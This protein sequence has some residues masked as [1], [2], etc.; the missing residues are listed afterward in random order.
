M[1]PM[2][3]ICIPDT[4]CRET[5]SLIDAGYG[6]RAMLPKQPISC[7]TLIRRESTLRGVR[8]S[9]WL[10]VMILTVVAVVSLQ[11][12]GQANARS[13]RFVKIPVASGVSSGVSAGCSDG[14]CS[15]CFA[16]TSL[17]ETPFGQKTMQDLRLGDHVRTMDKDG[18]IAFSPI[19]AFS[20]RRPHQPAKYIRISTVAGQSILVTTGHYMF[21]KGSDS[22]SSPNVHAWPYVPASKIKIGDLVPAIA[23]DNGMLVGA[24]VL[25]V[26]SEIHKGVY[27]PHTAAGAILVDGVFATELSTFVPHVLASS[28]THAMLVRIVSFFQKIGYNRIAAD[29]S[30]LVHGTADGVLSRAQW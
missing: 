19:I 30:I 25:N 23:D 18:K 12:M 13:L 20:S 11:S 22:A 2:Q 4:R 16:K 27:M 6:A 21:A 29:M 7:K 26:T 24:K 10:R 28:K 9:A 1:A 14:S 17:I 15:D 5:S 3:D 8:N